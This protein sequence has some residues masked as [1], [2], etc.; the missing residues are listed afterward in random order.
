MD[1]S[2]YKTQMEKAVKY[3]ETEFM[4]LQLGRASTWLVEN[5]TVHASYG[6]MKIPQVA[7]VTIMD[8][9]TLKIEPWDKKNVELL[10]KQFMM[11]NYD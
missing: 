5:I 7:H 3:L 6:D 8:Q 10:Q 2:T 9:Q 1:L 4:S 11:L